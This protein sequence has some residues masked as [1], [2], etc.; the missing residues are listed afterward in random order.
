MVIDK[1]RPF[2]I[3]KPCGLNTAEVA[4][5]REQLESRRLFTNNRTHTFFSWLFKFLWA[6][7]KHIAVDIVVLGIVLLWMRRKE[8]R[9]LEGAIRVL[10][11]DAVAQVQKVG[12]AQIASIGKIP[13]P[14][15]PGNGET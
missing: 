6:G 3:E 4:A 13:L 2:L 5:L 7:L 1:G 11:G 15:I 14:K 9:R 10:L 8:D 12:G